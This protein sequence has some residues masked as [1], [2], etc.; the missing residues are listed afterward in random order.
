MQFRMRSTQSRSS[1]ARHQ[2]HYIRPIALLHF[3]ASQR[4]P[5]Q[6]LGTTESRISSGLAPPDAARWGVRSRRL[7]CPRA[8]SRQT[9]I[10]PGHHSPASQSR[11]TPRIAAGHPQPCQRPLPAILERGRVH[12]TIRA[13]GRRSRKG[14]GVC[15]VERASGHAHLRQ[16]PGGGCEWSRRG[17]RTDLRGQD[18]RLPTSGGGAHLLRPGCCTLG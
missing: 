18:A 14:P 4:G 17:H 10:E 5:V 2:T 12:G 1:R 15:P 11:G 3:N 8:A 13:H 9:K 7:E 6:R 16:P